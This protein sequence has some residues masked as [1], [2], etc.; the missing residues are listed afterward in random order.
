M[1]VREGLIAIPHNNPYIS[2]QPRFSL[3]PMEFTGLVYAPLY[4]PG[5]NNIYSDRHQ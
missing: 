1:A 3:V 5:N 4:V 2:F